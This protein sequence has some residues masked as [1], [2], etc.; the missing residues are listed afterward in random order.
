MDVVFTHHTF[1][2][3]D[4]FIVTDLDDEFTTPYLDVSFE[5]WVTIFSDPYDMGG[6]SGYG[7]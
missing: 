5:Y 7:V 3:T 4:I 1:E 2:N 6:H